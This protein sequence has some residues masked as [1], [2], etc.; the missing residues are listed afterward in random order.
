LAERAA[1]ALAAGA[2]LLAVALQVRGGAYQSEFGSHPD[3]S[4]H[5]VTGVMVREYVATWPPQPPLRF[6]QDYYDHYPKVAIG[7]WPPAFYALQ[8][9]WTLVFSPSHVS[10]LL[11]MAALSATLATVIFL[12]L[13]REVGALVAAPTALLFLCL[14]L[15]QKATGM[16]MGEI[17]LALFCFGFALAL[18]RFLDRGRAQDALVS[19][20]FA[21]AA[22]LTK[23]NAF[24]LALAAPLALV[25]TR[26]FERLK[27]PALWAAAALVVALC[28]PWYVVTAPLAAEKTALVRPTL[29]YALAAARL[30]TVQLALAGGAFLLLLAL[31]GLG[32]T[33]PWTRTPRPTSGKWAAAAA[34]VVAVWAFHCVVPS[35]R[36][37][38]HM[39]LALPAFM[40]FVGA[41]LA[42]AARRLSRGAAHPR[43]WAVA[44]LG[45]A[46]LLFLAHGFAIPA[47]SWSGFAAP[48]D[49]LLGWPD[50]PAVTLVVS[51]ARGEGM[52]IS[53][54]AQREPRPRR[55]VL[56]GSKVLARSGWDGQDYTL[57]HRTPSEVLAFLDGRVDV[58]VLD[59][60]GTAAGEGHLDVMTRTVREHPTRFENA[61][62]FAVTRAGE[63]VDGAI[64][65][66][67]FRPSPRERQPPE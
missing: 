57:L 44:V 7:H 3:E 48:V 45:G 21:A 61:G 1:P 12:A 35:S 40:M 13:R 30:Y 38:R 24:A 17:P 4:A 65:V 23:G 39:V 19:A 5:Y 37:P 55:T 67:R 62:R 20:L 49:V 64:E 53:E 28:A 50:A 9:A 25:L 56:R 34:L 42:A 51:D 18:G 16:V 58:V 29:A 27:R 14:P 43:G 15:V 8:A 33:R 32:A 46:A 41:G 22:I 36:E 10:V 63:V 66:W 31:V 11:L 59:T 47:K 6:A 52:F 2:F 26:R 60:S 54:M